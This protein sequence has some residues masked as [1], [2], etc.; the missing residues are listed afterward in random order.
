MAT[1]SPPGAVSAPMLQ[2]L[3][4]RVSTDCVVETDPPSFTL[5]HIAMRIFFDPARQVALFRFRITVSTSR[6]PLFLDISPDNI[7][8]MSVHPGPPTVLHFRVAALTLIGP[9][10]MDPARRPCIHADGSTLD[11][12][13]CL[14]Q[15]KAMRVSLVAKTGEYNHILAKSQMSA[16]CEAVNR[17]GLRP[18]PQQ[19][20][21]QSLYRGHGGRVI[22][23]TELLSSS[24][25][26][27]ASLQGL[28]LLPPT[29]LFST[30]PPGDK[31]DDNDDDDNDE[32]PPYQ[33]RDRDLDLPPPPSPPRPPPPSKKR[34]RSHASTSISPVA[35]PKGPSSSSPPYHT[36]KHFDLVCGE[37]EK[38]LAELL[39]RADAKEK[40]F[41][42]LMDLLEIKEARVD[43]MITRLDIALANAQG[44]VRDA[45]SMS[46][47]SLMPKEPYKQQAQSS[48][49]G[50][51]EEEEEEDVEE[52]VKASSNATTASA[53]PPPPSIAA[54][55]SSHLSDRVQAY[56]SIQLD[57][58]RDELVDKYATHDAV[59]EVRDTLHEELAEDYVTTA[60]V[61]QRVSEEVDRVLS[62]YVEE[63]QM[64][65]AIREATDQAIE[66]VR[67]R[68]LAAWE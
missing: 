44:V 32:L 63:H 61:E 3:D 43:D 66:E 39:Q 54:S 1:N 33:D 17:G 38:M 52:E 23:M 42:G 4:G 18:D 27:P 11:A 65:E 45:G 21:L 56:V 51:E 64:F 48:V 29:D 6:D 41:T 16:L 12:L 37:R 15:H 10:E 13:R 9:K 62:R 24:P 20:D 31:D 7:T 68:V 60:M 8:N 34:R 50:G 53:S 28:D 22:S 19:T 35:A 30:V 26:S 46:S 36:Y 58:L 49:K 67:S 47:P 14:S 57:Q 25:S 55:V 5:A 2:G 40:R 59:D